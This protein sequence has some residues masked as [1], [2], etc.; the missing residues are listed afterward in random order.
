VIVSSACGR[1]AVTA[2]T[3]PGAPHAAASAPKPRDACKISGAIADLLASAIST[4]R[5][6]ANA[7]KILREVADLLLHAH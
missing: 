6:R 7:S 5:D 4:P 2:W 1:I 3:K